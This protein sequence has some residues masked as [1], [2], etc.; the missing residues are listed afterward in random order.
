MV[1]FM[2]KQYTG[3]AGI[4][5][6][7]YSDESVLYFHSDNT[8]LIEDYELSTSNQKEFQITKIKS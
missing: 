8:Y 3:V 1:L 7:V 2:Q 4:E 6:E 5:T